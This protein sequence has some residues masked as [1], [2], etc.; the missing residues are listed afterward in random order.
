MDAFKA[1]VKNENANAAI[2]VNLNITMKGQA[3]SGIAIKYA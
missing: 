2:H 3:L 1:K